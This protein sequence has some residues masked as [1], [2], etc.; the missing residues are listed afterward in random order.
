MVVLAWR[1]GAGDLRSLRSEPGREGGLWL[2]RQ[3][4]IKAQFKPLAVADLRFGQPR[5][6]RALDVHLVCARFESQLHYAPLGLV[7]S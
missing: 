5:F 3:K 4:L 7:L 1:D 6:G 2:G